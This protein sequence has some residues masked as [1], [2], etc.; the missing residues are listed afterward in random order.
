MNRIHPW[1]CSSNRW[2][3]TLVWKLTDGQWKVM[4]IRSS[5]ACPRTKAGCWLIPV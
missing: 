3:R 5:D 4:H 1:M 2:K